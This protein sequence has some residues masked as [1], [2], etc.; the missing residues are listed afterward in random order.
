[1]QTK[2]VEN[3]FNQTL[4]SVHIPFSSLKDYRMDFKPTVRSIARK[5][6]TN[7]EFYELTHLQKLRFC[8]YGKWRDCLQSGRLLWYQ[9]IRETTFYAHIDWIE[10]LEKPMR[11]QKNKPFRNLYRNVKFKPFE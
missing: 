7:I 6:N 9:L 11:D 1:M 8:I 10:D 3:G 4:I 5:T 2:R